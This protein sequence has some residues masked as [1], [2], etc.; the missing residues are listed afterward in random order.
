[1][2]INI[3]GPRDHHVKCEVGTGAKTVN[4]PPR[5]Q[6]HLEAGGD[7]GGC[8]GEDGASFVLPS[9]EGPCPESLSSSFP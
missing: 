1:M 2:V 6:R 3:A 4:V 5:P 9:Q 7:A 8:T